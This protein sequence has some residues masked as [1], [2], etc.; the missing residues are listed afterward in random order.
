MVDITESKASLLL[1]LLAL[2]IGCG[3]TASSKIDLQQLDFS[4]KSTS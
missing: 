1:T 3:F 2:K 4:F